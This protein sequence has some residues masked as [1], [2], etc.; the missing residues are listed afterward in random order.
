MTCTKWSLDGGVDI[1]DKC[2]VAWEEQ[3][4]QGKR[5]HNSLM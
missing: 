2:A 1:L 5:L 3:S 4:G